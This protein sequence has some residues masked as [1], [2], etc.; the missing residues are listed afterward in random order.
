[1][2]A[3]KG[4]RLEK[5][6]RNEGFLMHIVFFEPDIP[7]NL[8][9]ALRLCAAFDCVL[10]IIEPCGFP[11]NDKAIKRAAMDYAQIAKKVHHVDWQ[12]FLDYHAQ[13]LNA[14]RLILFTTKTHVSYCDIAYHSEDLLLFGRE[15]AGVPEHVAQSAT[16]SV[17]IPM[18]PQARSINVVTAA[19]MA[20]GEAL[21]QTNGF[22]PIT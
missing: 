11:L 3:T 6:R 12:G 8:G 17:T 14:S 20:L 21:R 16:I 5:A 10:H 2:H 13:N 9:A 22:N 19:A 15:S 18:N 1:L 4:H 7:Q